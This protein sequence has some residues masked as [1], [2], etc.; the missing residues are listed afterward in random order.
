MMTAG[1]QMEQLPVERMGK[2]GQGMPVSGVKAGQGPTQVGPGEPVLDV[3]V[4]DDVAKIVKVD[5][6]VVCNRPINEEDG[7][8]QGKTNQACAPPAPKLIYRGHRRPKISRNQT[9]TSTLMFQRIVLWCSQRLPQWFFDRAGY[10]R[11][12]MLERHG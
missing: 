11:K 9:G 6:L 3:P 8:R 10:K 4:L 5:E 1:V 7:S 2:P 12:R